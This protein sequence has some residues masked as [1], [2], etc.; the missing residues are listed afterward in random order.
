M[1]KRIHSNETKHSL[2]IFALHSIA[3]GDE[4]FECYDGKCISMDKVCDE[5][6]DCESGEDEESINCNIMNSTTFA[7][8]TDF[9]TEPTD[10]DATTEIDINDIDSTPGSCKWFIC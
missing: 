2:A 10:I 6:K 5:I 4:E 8:E 9:D 3:C 7:G 1:K